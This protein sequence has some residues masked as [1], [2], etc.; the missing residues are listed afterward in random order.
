MKFEVVVEEDFAHSVEKV[1]AA[2]TERKALG[3]W[4]LDTD[5]FRAEVGCKFDMCCTNDDGTRD[6]YRMEL[7]ELEAPRRMLWSWVLSGKEDQGLTQVEFT[8]TEI[9][10]GTK[11]TV[12]HRGDRDR[13]MLEKFESGWPFKL[14]ALA[15][16]LNTSAR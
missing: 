2:M 12:R 9:E 4:L 7:L 3:E 15:D 13:E 10:G 8:L 1:W 5:D 6:V 11:V 14:R 16:L